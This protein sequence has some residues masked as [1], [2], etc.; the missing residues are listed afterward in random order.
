LAEI[1]SDRISKRL[2]MKV[3][4]GLSLGQPPGPAQES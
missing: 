3:F 2:V 1:H 4:M